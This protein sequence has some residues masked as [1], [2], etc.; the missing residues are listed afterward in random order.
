MAEHCGAGLCGWLREHNDRVPGGERAKAGFHGLDLYSLYRSIEEVISYLDR[1]DPEAAKRAR[2]RYA[3][4]DH[5]HTD[6]DAQ[7]LGVRGRL[8]S[9]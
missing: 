1:V 6:G 5:Y 7:G 4:F 3:C 9:G 8:R 2:E